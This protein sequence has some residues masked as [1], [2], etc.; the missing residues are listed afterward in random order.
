MSRKKKQLK[1]GDISAKPQ[2]PLTPQMNALPNLNLIIFAKMWW[3]CNLSKTTERRRSPL[4]VP[5]AH[6]FSLA[7]ETK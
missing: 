6:L 7:N 1:P 5:S 3:I 4:V 2:Y